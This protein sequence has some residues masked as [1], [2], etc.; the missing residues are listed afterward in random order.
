LENQ[1]HPQNSISALILAAGKSERFGAPKVLQSFK[2]VPF[3]VRIVDSLRQAGIQSIYLVL[4]FESEKMVKKLPEIEKINIVINENYEFGQFSSLQT[5]IRKL[6]SDISG[7][8]VCLI[9][10][11]HLRSETVKQIVNE[12]NAHPNRI[13][14][15]TFKHHGGHP[16]YIPKSLLSEIRETA[17]SESLRHVFLNNLHFIHRFE[18]DDPLIVEDVDTPGDLKKIE[19][20]WT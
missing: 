5:G 16:V 6:P 13:I 2:N 17:I 20:Q 8:L 12:V 7:C 11:P 14:I 10:Q 1:L 18:V 9:D 4:G 3:L 19:K 15:P